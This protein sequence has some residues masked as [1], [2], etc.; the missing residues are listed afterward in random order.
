M[1]QQDLPHVPF[2]P[3]SENSALCTFFS[4]SCHPCLQISEGSAL[5]QQRPFG[6][7]PPNPSGSSA[8]QGPPWLPPTTSMSKGKQKHLLTSPVPPRPA[9]GSPDVPVRT[10]L[11]FGEQCLASPCDTQREEILPC[12][13]LITAVFIPSPSSLKPP[14]A[15][16]KQLLINVPLE[17]GFITLLHERWGGLMSSS[18]RS[19]L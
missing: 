18:H 12:V 1:R 7:P 9:L 11:S 16:I 2:N 4:L 14:D 5:V 19:S 13:D 6:D 10:L 15:L 17:T 3:A 8:H